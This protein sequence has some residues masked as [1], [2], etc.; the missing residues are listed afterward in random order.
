[1]LTKT[2]I[3]HLLEK[4]EKLFAAWTTAAEEDK[5]SFIMQISDIDEELSP[6]RPHKK[7]ITRKFINNN[8]NV[9][10]HD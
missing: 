8:I 2:Q 7:K 3:N 9:I 5:V 10:M 1:M 4:R 6:Y